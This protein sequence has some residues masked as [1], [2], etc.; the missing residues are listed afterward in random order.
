MGLNFYINF[1]P[2]LRHLALLICAY[3]DYTSWCCGH[4]SGEPVSVPNHPWMKNPF[5]ISNLNF[6][7]YCFMTFPQVLSLVPGEKRSVTAPCAGPGFW[8]S[9]WVA[10]ISGCSLLEWN[11]MELIVE[12]IVELMEIMGPLITPCCWISSAVCNM[13]FSRR[14]DAGPIGIRR[15]QLLPYIAAVDN[16]LGRYGDVLGKWKTEALGTPIPTSPT[17][18]Q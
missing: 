15:I 13:E 11:R 3:H 17:S 10:S 16:L 7:W 1:S 18:H 8:W 14:P 2:F 6:P 12:L 9:L 5:P 4:F